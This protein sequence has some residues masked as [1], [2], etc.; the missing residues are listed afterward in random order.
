MGG[1]GAVCPLGE[2]VHAR[3]TFFSDLEPSHPLSLSPENQPDLACG[4]EEGPRGSRGEVGRA[5]L[6]GAVRTEIPHRSYSFRFTPGHI[7]QVELPLR[8][9]PLLRKPTPKRFT[10]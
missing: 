5:V 7:Q 8:I 1:A 9:F 4:S 10:L 2:H 3:A 6:K